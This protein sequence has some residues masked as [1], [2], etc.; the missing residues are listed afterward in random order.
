MPSAAEASVGELDA[1]VRELLV[2]A[3]LYRPRAQDP[4]LSVT[5]L[6][7]SVVIGWSATAPIPPIRAGKAIRSALL[8]LLA[9]AG[10]SARYQRSPGSRTGTITVTCPGA[11]TRGADDKH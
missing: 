4:E 10:L 7:D 1:R 5:A 2:A 6:G 11:A 3:G 9:D 8:A